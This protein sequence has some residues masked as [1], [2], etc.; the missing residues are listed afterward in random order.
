MTARLCRIAIYYDGNYFSKVSNYYAFQHERRARLN[1]Q[2]LHEFVVSETA[3]VEALE[4]RQCQVV[5]AAYFR[6]R[7]NA[8]QALEQDRLYA[9]RVF[10]DALMRADIAVHQTPIAMTDGR[11]HEKGIDVWLALEAYEMAR[12]KQHD[13]V[14]LISGDGDFVPLVRK[15]NTLGTRVMLLGWDFEYERDGRLMQTRVSSA[16]LERV[17]H[18]VMMDALIDARERRGDPLVNGLFLPRMAEP[19]PRAPAPPP[20]DPQPGEGTLINVL[21]D[22]NCGFIR[23]ADGGDNIFFHKSELQGVALADLPRD[24]PLRFLLTQSDRGPVAREV[25]LSGSSA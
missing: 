1:L 17:N 12:L 4:P 13:W 16:L 9:E 10:D 22:K 21:L 7:L 2:G 18:P 24:A 3:R 23:P 20:A 15:L 25:K 11:P 5:D 8:P 14:V 19:A 6:G